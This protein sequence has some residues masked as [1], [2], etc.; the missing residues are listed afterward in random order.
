[1]AIKLVAVDLDDTLLDNN[2]T[3]SPRT[4]SAIRQAIAGGVTVTMATGRMFSSAVR[5]AAELEL[6]VPLITYNGA[7]IRCSLSGETLLHKPLEEATARGI[8]AFFKERGWYIQVYLDDKLYVKEFDDNARLYE[9]LSGI[10][11]IPVGEE[12]YS[13]AGTPTKMLA[14]AEPA[15]IPEIGTAVKN[16]FGDKVYAAASKAFYL[17]MTNPTVNKGIALDFLAGRLGIRQ[18]EVMAIGD[19]VNDLDMLAYAGLGVAMGNASPAV[20][21]AANVVTGANDAD[22][23]AEAIEKYVLNK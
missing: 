12:L 18:E 13:L 5:Y 23:V 9:E 14:L 15:M 22:G 3:V 20:K 11:A 4:A 10:R 17:E 2:L 19:S 21:A 16:A 8:L 1:M 7:L 6:D